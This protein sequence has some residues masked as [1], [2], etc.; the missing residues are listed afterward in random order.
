MTKDLQRK[1]AAGDERFG[2]HSRCLG[3]VLYLMTS[4]TTNR[5]RVQEME[6]MLKQALQQ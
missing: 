5:W 3:N 6:G 1:L 2:V 4:V